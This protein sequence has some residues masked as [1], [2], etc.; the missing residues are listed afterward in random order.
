[1]NYREG[2]PTLEKIS[3]EVDK[4]FDMKQ[5]MNFVGSEDELFQGDCVRHFTTNEVKE[6]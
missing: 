5:L 4:I 2:I 6:I 3:D 1:L